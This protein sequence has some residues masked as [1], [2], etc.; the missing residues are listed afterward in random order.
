MRDAASTRIV[1]KFYGAAGDALIAGGNVEITNKLTLAR[2]PGNSVNDAH[3]YTAVDRFYDFRLFNQTDEQI[4]V[5][6]DQ[7]DVLYALFNGI[8]TTV[9]TKSANAGQTHMQSVGNTLYFGNGIDDKKWLQSL[10]AWQAGFNWAVNS[11]PLFTTFFIDENGNIQQLTTAGI[12][13]GSEPVW[14][15]VVPS[16]ANDFQGGLT[17]DGT[18]VWTNRGNPI[19]NW[20]S[21]LRS[22]RSLLRLALRA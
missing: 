6:I 15:T 13:A 4:K 21:R 19:E 22:Q 1:E 17:T 2:R 20:E 9:W 18:A 7:A 10:V 3:S 5:M 16:A 8:R 14:S 11:T 12:S